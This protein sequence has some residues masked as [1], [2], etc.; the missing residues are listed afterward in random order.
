MKRVEVVPWS[1]A[2]MKGPGTPGA[3]RVAREEPA[4]AE[5]E[6]PNARRERVAAVVAAP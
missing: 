6:E 2:P 5:E 1:I 4:P 3:W